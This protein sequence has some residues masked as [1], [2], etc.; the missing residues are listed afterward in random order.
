MKGT[1]EIAEALAA[2]PDVARVEGNPHIHNHLPQPGPVD[3]AP[4]HL[5]RPADD[6]AG[7]QLH[8]RAAGMGAGIHRAE[9]LLLRAPTPAFAGRITRLSRTIAAGT[10]MNADHDY[11]WHDSI[12]DSVGNPCGNDS[13]FPCDDLVSRL[14]HH[15]HGDR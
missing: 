9:T 6:R 12:H 3:E 1:R 10:D 11:N 4:P 13:P 8:A 5:Q 15:R 7:H 2:R 14:A